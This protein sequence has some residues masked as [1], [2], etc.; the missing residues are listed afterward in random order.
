M[1][2]ELVLYM[3]TDIDATTSRSNLCKAILLV[4]QEQDDDLEDQALAAATYDYA[5]GRLP[6]PSLVSLQLSGAHKLQ[7]PQSVETSQGQH[8]SSRGV[9]LP[10]DQI[11]ISQGHEKATVEPGR[12]KKIKLQHVSPSFTSIQFQNSFHQ[13]EKLL[14]LRHKE[15]ANN[16]GP[17][18]FRNNDTNA[19][20]PPVPRPLLLGLFE[21]PAALS[22]ELLVVVPPG[23]TDGEGRV[24]LGGSKDGVGG[25]PC[26]GVNAGDGGE[27][28]GGSEAGVGGEPFGGTDPGDGGEFTGGEGG[29]PFGGSGD[30]GGGVG[31][32]FCAGGGGEKGGESTLGGGEGELG[33]V[34]GC[35]GGEVGGGSS[36]G[37]GGGELVGTVGCGG[38]ET[39]GGSTSGGGDELTGGL[40]G[41][42]LAGGLGGGLTVGGE[43][44][45]GGEAIGGGDVTL[46]GG[47]DCGSVGEA[48]G[49]EDCWGN[50]GG[51]EDTGGAIALGC[52]AGTG[53]E[54]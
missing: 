12:E 29:E 20:V 34:V 32:G 6:V 35:G 9:D 40:G 37:G 49:G 51:R 22:L 24:F 17:V 25:E 3:T 50:V 33:G 13:K 30:C 38:G 48:G 2:S 26:G 19:T 42:E 54:S 4:K 41:G 10:A 16:K 27:F 11:P 14:S 15:N 31:S 1:F 36:F 8:N 53:E 46:L 39:G 47:G 44:S 18:T 28:V 7:L 45:V 23:G 43:D 21:L 5:I 52:D